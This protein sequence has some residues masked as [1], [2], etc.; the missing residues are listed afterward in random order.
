MWWNSNLAFGENTTKSSPYCSTRGT[1]TAF[2][3]VDG[4]VATAI[5]DEV[6]HFAFA[7]GWLV[8][9]IRP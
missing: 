1:V 9:F 7:F 2:G 5:V 8:F 4:D 6:S 3:L